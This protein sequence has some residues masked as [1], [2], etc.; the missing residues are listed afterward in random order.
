MWLSGLSAGCEPRV[1]GSIPSQG[2]CLGPRLGSRCGP[3]ERHPHIDVSLPLFLPPFPSLSKIKQKKSALRERDGEG[4]REKT[5]DYIQRSHECT[6]SIMHFLM[7][8]EVLL[9]VKGL[10]TFIISVSF[11]PVYCFSCVRRFDLAGSLLTSLHAIV[12]L[13]Y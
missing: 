5:L 1:A 11:S 4:G 7:A 10:S 2:T 8:P 13:W 6:L 9:P 12:S 3:C